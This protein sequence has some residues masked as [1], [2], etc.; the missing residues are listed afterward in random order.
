M[1]RHLEEKLDLLFHD[2]S[3]KIMMLSCFA[4]MIVLIV[5]I[6][7]WFMIGDVPLDLYKH[8]LIAHSI[9]FVSYC[10]K[11]GYEFKKACELKDYDWHS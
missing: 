10:C 3:H 6:L 11:Q 8:V 7:S 4:S 1:R 2:F 5:S 9:C